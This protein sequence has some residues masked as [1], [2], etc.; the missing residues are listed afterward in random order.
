MVFAR[1]YGTAHSVGNCALF[2]R[3]ETIIRATSVVGRLH[4]TSTIEF[5]YWKKTSIAFRWPS[6][7]CRLL[8]F[9]GGIDSG[10]LFIPT[11]T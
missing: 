1:G 6:G 7:A 8:R 9:H 11:T 4:I 2:L 5:L 3:F 10:R